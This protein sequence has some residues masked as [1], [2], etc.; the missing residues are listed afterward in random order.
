M[1]GERLEL[2]KSELLRRLDRRSRS[3]YGGPFPGSLFNDLQKDALI[4]ALERSTNMGLAPTYFATWRHYRRALQVQRLR[5]VG[6]VGRDPLRVQLFIRG[7]GLKV[8]EVRGSLRDEFLRGISELRPVLRSGYFRNRREPGPRHLAAIERQLGP[9]DPRF[10]AAGLEQPADFILEVMRVGLGAMSHSEL[11][12]SEGW[13]LAGL[14]DHPLPTLLT[15]SLN[16]SDADYVF[17]RDVLSELHA[18]MFRPMLGR[19]FIDSAKWP[20]L[21]LVILL[22]AG[23][24]EK[25]SSGRFTVADIIARIPRPEGFERLGR[26]ILGELWQRLERSQER[27]K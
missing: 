5:S 15:E 18:V 3:R 25:S 9:L 13:L 10:E 20:A 2:S 8:S 14:H 24:L 16:A 22:V 19:N 11:K 1:T 4:P 17:A 26:E 6:I 23:H 21:T 12:A 7:Y 27:A